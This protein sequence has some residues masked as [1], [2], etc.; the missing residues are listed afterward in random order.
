MYPKIGPL[1]CL[2]LVSRNEWYSL[3]WVRYEAESD[4]SVHLL[5]LGFW[6]E[7]SHD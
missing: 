7:G 3:R 4:F 6:E 1:K 5:P 2:R